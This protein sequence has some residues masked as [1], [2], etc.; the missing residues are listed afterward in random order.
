M[1]AATATKT[2]NFIA[3]DA[4]GNTVKDVMTGSSEQAVASRL[5]ERGL[6][7][8]SVLDATPGGLNMEIKIPGMGDK[9]GLKDVAIMSRQLATMINSGLSLLRALMILVEQTEN[10][11]LA[12]VLTEVR[13]EVETGRSFSAA[14]G[15]HPKVFPP[16][17]INMVKAGEVGGFLDQALISLA[18]N[19]EKEVAL[20]GKIKSAMAY[21][22]VVFVIAI[23]AATAMLLFIIPVF[24]NMFA[25]LG[26]SL[27]APTRFLMALSDFLKIAI[28]PII[29]LLIVFAWW[30]SKH[31]NDRKVRE[32]LDPIKLKMPVFGNLN[33]KIALSRFSRNL[34]AMLAAGV[35]I[36]Q[37]L[38]IV[39]EASG[40][41]VVEHATQDIM[42]AVRKGRS[43]TAPLQASPVFPP[44]MAQMMAVGE[45]TG[46]LDDMLGKIADFYDQEIESTTE[47]LTSLIEPLMILFVGVMVGGMVITMYLPMFSIYN[48]IG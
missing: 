14:L 48:Q 2:F 1:M 29:L 35:P 40:N 12:A 18:E 26:G 28:I 37:A 16:I 20:R 13:S 33:K 43:I 11:A 38:D 27:P 30:W 46:A 34:S 42:D 25:T 8:V 7:P 6:T 10:K 32:F 31:K 9:I 47:Q 24:G 44:M 17:M 45:D 5:R 22:I 41:V 36:L 15:K 4:S 23:V 19:F 39:G 21:P 3:R